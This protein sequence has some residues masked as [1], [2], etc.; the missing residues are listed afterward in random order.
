MTLKKLGII[1][2]NS[3]RRVPCCLTGNGSWVIKFYCARKS[4]KTERETRRE[5]K[6]R[7]GLLQFLPRR[8]IV[9][10]RST[11]ENTFSII[12]PGSGKRYS[13]PPPSFRC[14]III[15]PWLRKHRFPE[16]DGDE[17]WMEI[18][19]NNTARRGRILFQSI[20][21]NESPPLSP[22]SLYRV[23]NRRFQSPFADS[24]RNTR[25]WQR[26]QPSG[27]NFLGRTIDPSIPT[28][29]W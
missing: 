18:G 1:G 11:T 13:F 2:R 8:S 9:C 27:K 22:S 14:T 4:E 20:S 28:L 26:Q 7:W 15:I 17:G 6:S 29:A 10:R 24:F 23:A 19:V 25:W 21:R 16:I 12:Q 3:Y 5:R